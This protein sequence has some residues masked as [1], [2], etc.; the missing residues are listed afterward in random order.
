MVYL[1]TV[2]R[3]IYPVVSTWMMMVTL[4]PKAVST[5][6][7]MAASPTCCYRWGIDR[8]FDGVVGPDAFGIV[9]DEY[10]AWF[11]S[12][13]LDE[14]QVLDPPRY[15]IGYMDDLGGLNSDTFIKIKPTL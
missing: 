12:R 8:D 7:G 1:P 3:V 15:E 6:G 4:Q 10:L 14:N 5:H 13:P 11:A 2:I 9:S